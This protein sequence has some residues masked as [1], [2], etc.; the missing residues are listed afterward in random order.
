M[1]QNRKILVGT[2]TYDGR[3]PVE[4]VDCLLRSTTLCI[5]NNIELY[6]IMLKGEHFIEKGRNDIFDLAIKNDF[7]DLIYID[8]DILWN[9]EDLIK[10]LEHDVDCVSATYRRKTTEEVSYPVKFTR[11]GEGSDLI[12][13]SEEK[14]LWKVYGVPA[15]FLRI[16]KN[17][18]KKLFEN[19]DKYN[20]VRG[21]ERGGDKAIVFY[22]SFCEKT[23]EFVS[24]DIGFCNNWMDSCKAD[25]WLDSSIKLQHQ[26]SVNF[27]GDPDEWIKEMI[28]QHGIN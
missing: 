24:E 15:G 18:M 12:E 10:L 27:S 14:D 25:L 17:G 3:L 21:D 7:D 20:D 2:L 11:N 22:T 6:P 1:N 9:P 23:R 26:G 28:N 4:W 5:Q 19:C 8:S 16:N 13:Y